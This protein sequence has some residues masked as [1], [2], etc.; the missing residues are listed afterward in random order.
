MLQRS[1]EVKRLHAPAP[2][3]RRLPSMPIPPA[4]IKDGEAEACG[5]I[6]TQSPDGRVSSGYWS[7]TTGKFDWTFTWDEFAHILEGQ[8]T[9]KQDK[10]K[11]CKLVLP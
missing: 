6:L 4:W 5:T 9:I 1:I 11:T 10:G 7:C 2:P 8:V 3:R